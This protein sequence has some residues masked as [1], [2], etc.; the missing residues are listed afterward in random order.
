MGPPPFGLSEELVLVFREPRFLKSRVLHMLPKDR[1]VRPSST[2]ANFTEKAYR[3]ARPLRRS[4]CPAALC[5][6][7][8]SEF[9][10]VQRANL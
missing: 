4:N 6:R 5:K 10:C 7:R 1:A 8:K 9:R 2:R 3:A